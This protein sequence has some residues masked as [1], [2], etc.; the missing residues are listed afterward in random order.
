MEMVKPTRQ[1]V[2]L[3]PACVAE[4]GA[5]IGTMSLQIGKRRAIS[6][7]RAYSAWHFV[8]RNGDRSADALPIDK[9][10]SIDV[11]ISV[12]LRLTGGL[13]SGLL[14]AFEVGVRHNT[15]C[16]FTVYRPCAAAGRQRMS[17]HAPIE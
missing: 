15:D 11:Q 3:E 2:I 5:L 4:V 8:V 13:P 7:R 10:H 9:R 12:D 17:R 14:D 16:G 1:A 6:V